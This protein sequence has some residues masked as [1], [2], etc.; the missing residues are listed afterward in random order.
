MAF[1]ADDGSRP[2]P[3][4]PPRVTSGSSTTTVFQVAVTIAPPAGSERVTI[5][6]VIDGD[7]IEVSVLSGG[8]E[9]VRLIGINTPESGECFSDEASLA[10][11]GLLADEVVTMTADTTDRDQYDRL[12]R[13]LWLDRGTLVNEVMVRGGH[14]QARDFPPDSL[15]AP[16]IAAAQV[17]AQVEAIG[18]WAEDACGPPI[19]ADLRVIDVLPDPPGSDTDNLAGEWV[20]IVNVGSDEVSLQ[21]WTLKDESSRHRYR[22]PEN[23]VI[24]ARATVRVRTGCG[25]DDD[26]TLHWCSGSAVWNNEGDTAF[27]LEPNGNI[28]SF[29]N[30]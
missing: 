7:T 26:E 4:A 27:L 1:G 12:L 13:Y 3:H 24:P 25:R 22:F 30:Y 5:T 11:G 2:G 6:R 15:H 19:G 18:I 9:V 17:S 21:G 8:R 10:L 23:F 28:V 16:R 14:A 20:D 29:Y